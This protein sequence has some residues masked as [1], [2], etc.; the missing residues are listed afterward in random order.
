MERGRVALR[1]LGLIGAMLA[2]HCAGQQEGDG[3]GPVA[4]G[5]SGNPGGAIGSGGGAPADGGSPAG[6][7]LGPGGTTGD[8]D[9]LSARYPGDVGLAQDPSVLFFDDCEAGWGRWR[10][11]KSVV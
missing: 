11:R 6:G 7:G 10:D 1:G 8:A 9:S 3:T 5:G 4:T 2:L